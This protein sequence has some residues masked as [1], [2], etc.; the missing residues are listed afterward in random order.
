[1]IFNV[2]IKKFF[3]ELEE[4]ATKEAIQVLRTEVLIEAGINDKKK[5]I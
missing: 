2:A 1:M 5:V 4:L 3:K